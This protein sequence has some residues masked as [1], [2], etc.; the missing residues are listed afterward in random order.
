MRKKRKVTA[1]R[2]IKHETR[3]KMELVGK[4]KL[5]EINGN[6]FNE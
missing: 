4:K 6:L 2:R 3:K 1:D 5:T